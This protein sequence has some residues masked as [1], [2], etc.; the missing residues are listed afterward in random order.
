M[1]LA[2]LFYD[3]GKELAK[4]LKISKPSKNPNELRENL[5]EYQTQHKVYKILFGI[6]AELLLKA[7]YIRIGYRIYELKK[8]HCLSE[9]RCEIDRTKTVR[10]SELIEEKNLKC[11]FSG[12]DAISLKE[13]IEGLKVIQKWLCRTPINMR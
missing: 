11:I 2:N 9:W 10:F 8:P 12:N 4:R 5:I 3:D 6:S 1:K 13:F 7:L